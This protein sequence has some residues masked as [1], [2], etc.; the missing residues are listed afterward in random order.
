MIYYFILK[1][2]IFAECESVVDNNVHH[3]NCMVDI[4]Y[5]DTNEFFCSALN[6]YAMQCAENNV[7]LEWRNEVPECGK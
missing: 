4:C 7:V 2:Q 6:A 5:G 1:Q 3:E